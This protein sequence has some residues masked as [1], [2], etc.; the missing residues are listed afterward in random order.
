VIEAATAEELR[1]A[2]RRIGEACAAAG[3]AAV[4]GT[5]YR[6]AMAAPGC[7]G[8]GAGAGAGAGSLPLPPHCYYNSATAFDERGAVVG[9]QHKV[10]LVPTDSW[11]APGARL[12]VI[13]LRG[14]AVSIIICHDKRYP[15]LV[16]LPGARTTPPPA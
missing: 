3:V 12:Q 11:A 4:V 16:R 9:R 2:E 13:W 6:A 8:A 14:V 10:Q 1:E 5:P 7:G 15:E